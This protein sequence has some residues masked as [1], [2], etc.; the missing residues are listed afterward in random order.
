ML[1]RRQFIVASAAVASASILRAQEAARV[2]PRIDGAWWQIAEQ[3]DLG[4]LT[5]PKQQPVDFA[6]WR[7][8]DG[9]WQLLS[10]IRNTQC[11]GKTRL[12][13]RWEAAKI[14]DEKWKPMGI[15]MQADDKLGETP[16][17][18][19]A[20]HVIPIDGR[21]EMFYGDWVHI[22]RASSA[23]GKTFER[24]RKADGKTGMFDEGADANARDAMVIRV[25]ELWH[26]Y[27]TA[28]PGRK[29]AVYCRTSKDR[30]EWGQSKIVAVGGEA[31]EGPF[32]AECPHVVFHAPSRRY[33]LFRTQRYGQNAMTRVYASADPLDFG[34]NDDA[35]LVAKLPVAAPEIV[36][37]DGQMYIAALRPGLDGIQV[38]KFSWSVVGG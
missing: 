25:G 12:L 9:T 11:G 6:I 32:T 16:G 31:G 10:C 18:L 36:E 22:C 1:S 37:Q 35:K 19:Q 29:G 23:D 14:T 38:A 34:V 4:P 28:H 2:I 24:I 13:H 33:F 5:S 20:P 15:L 30:A 21:Y 26:C 17:G 7:A 3:P 27:Y 8:A